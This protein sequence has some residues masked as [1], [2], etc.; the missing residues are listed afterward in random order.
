MVVGKAAVQRDPDKLKKKRVDRNLTTFS[1]NKVTVQHL[2]W[3][4]RSTGW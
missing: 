4:N 2:G 1:K 3:N